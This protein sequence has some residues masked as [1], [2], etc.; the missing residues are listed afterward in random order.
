MIAPS[1]AGIA[2]HRG[3]NSFH[4]FRRQMTGKPRRISLCH[5][6]DA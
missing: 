1:E 2:S 5:L 4:L 3:K 6:R